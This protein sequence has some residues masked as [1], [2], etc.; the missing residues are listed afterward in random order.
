MTQVQISS[1]PEYF[2][3][4]KSLDMARDGNGIL[5]VTMNDSSGGPITFG[6]QDHTDFTEAFYRIDRDYD[7]K[8][9][10]LTGAIDFMASMDFD[11][12]LIEM[13]ANSNIWARLFDE[14]VQIV[15]NLANIRVPMIAAV[16]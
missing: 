11:A 6:G 15:E 16:E 9:V 4:F 10:I 12:T 13:M 1:R 8:V 2:D 14:G 7:N 3:Q 5:I